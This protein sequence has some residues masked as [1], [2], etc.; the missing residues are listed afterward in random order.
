MYS[1]TFHHQSYLKLLLLYT[2]RCSQQTRKC[3]LLMMTGEK[4][5]ASL[6]KKFGIC[7]NEAADTVLEYAMYK[8]SDGTAVGHK[9]VLQSD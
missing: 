7:S 4:H 8:K 9:L 6:C 2:S 3:V 5:V 1:R